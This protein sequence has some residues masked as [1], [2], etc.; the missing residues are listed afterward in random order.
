MNC[1]MVDDSLSDGKVLKGAYGACY[2]GL[3]IMWTR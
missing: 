1:H 2:W 3:G